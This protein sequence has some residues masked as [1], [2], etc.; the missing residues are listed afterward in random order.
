MKAG[1][2][3]RYAVDETKPTATCCMCFCDR[4][5]TSVTDIGA[6][7]QLVPEHLTSLGTRSLMDRAVCLYIECYQLGCCFDVLYDIGTYALDND[8]Y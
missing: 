4:K 8:R 6:S 3:V 2:T 7:K 1:V 5:R